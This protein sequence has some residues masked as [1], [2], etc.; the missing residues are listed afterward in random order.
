MT[1]PFPP[2][3]RQRW[4]QR[5][6]MVMVLTW[7]TMMLLAVAVTVT[8]ATCSSAIMNLVV[9]GR[10]KEATAATAAGA[11]KLDT[12]NEAMRNV[13]VDFHS[14]MYCSAFTKKRKSTTMTRTHDG[15]FDTYDL[16]LRT[17]GGNLKNWSHLHS[18]FWPHAFTMKKQDPWKCTPSQQRRK[19]IEMRSKRSRSGTRDSN[20]NSTNSY[21]LLPSKL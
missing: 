8:M 9:D 3:R 7:W 20:N 15:I 2:R 10:R 17:N 21:L 4:V 14:A 1:R 16:W 11:I 18:D 12:A 13:M 5:R 6:W 19:S